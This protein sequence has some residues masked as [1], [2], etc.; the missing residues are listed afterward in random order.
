VFLDARGVA[1]GA[2]LECE[3]CVIGAGAAGITLARQLEAIPA[4][5]VVLESGGFETDDETQLLSDGEVVGQKYAP[6]TATRVRVFGGSTS[7]WEGW[8]RPLDKRDLVERVWVSDSGWPLAWPEL[9]RYYAPAHVICQLGPYDYRPERWSRITGRQPLPLHDDR[10]LEPAVY[11]FSPTRFGAVYRQELAR[12]ANVRVFL[13]ANATQIVRRPGARAVERVDVATLSGR[14]FTVKARY[15]VVAAGGIENARLLLA[16]QLGNDLVGRYFTE[17]P[18]ASAALVALPKSLLGDSFYRLRRAPDVYVRG[19][20][21]TS[22]RLERERQILR[23]GA[24]LDRIADDPLVPHGSSEERRA[25]EL[26][27]AVAAVARSLDGRGEHDLYALFVRW[28]QSPNPDSR[29]TLGSERD[30]LGVPKV[31]LDW[32]LTELDRRTV[33]EALKALAV[34]LG[35]AGLGRLYARPMV[36]EAFWPNIFFGF[37]HLGTTRMHRHPGRG[38]VD[39][40]CRIHGLENAYVAG[41]SVF[42]TGGYANP[43]LTIVA[44]SLRLADHLKARLV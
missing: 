5:V 31:R 28:E 21:A 14:R 27:E 13:H 16:S 1:D 44:L 34:A 15:V 33:R 8:C 2:E 36:E 19:A 11:Q 18:H 17:H 35:A 6:L 25:E 4:R 40:D 7:H 32:R 10:W 38:V 26:G 30:A 37:H 23:L 24:T 3:V 9:D 29:I 43:T 20:L 41:S 22:T 12:A 42:P 39:A